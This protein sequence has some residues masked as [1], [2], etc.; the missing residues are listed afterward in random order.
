MKDPTIHIRKSTLRDI[1]NAYGVLFSEELLNFI[2]EE[3]RPHN[4][5]SRTLVVTNAAG[6]RDYAKAKEEVEGENDTVTFN[7]TLNNERKRLFHIFTPIT[8]QDNAW[9]TLT[10][11]ANIGNQMAD[12]FKLSKPQ[13]YAIYIRLAVGLM[14]KGYA[15][16]KMAS[17]KDRIYELYATELEVTRDGNAEGTKVLA[18]I[19]YEEAEKFYGKDPKRLDEDKVHFMKAREMADTIP[20][21]YESF[22]MAQIQGLEFTGNFP[23]P[24]QLYSAQAEHRYLTRKKV[25]QSFVSTIGSMDNYMAD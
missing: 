7:A 3:A 17:Y 16:N 8:K 6:K 4:I 15:L 19:Y 20:A 14:R 21:D 24:Y 25:T 10:K 9:G 2:M 13:A 23:E 22:V 12:D 11:L 1:I 18:Q 5:T